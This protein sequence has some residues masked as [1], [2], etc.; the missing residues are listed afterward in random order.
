MV[1][2]KIELMKTPIAWKTIL[3]FVLIAAVFLVLNLT[4]FDKEVKNFFYSLSSPVQK[5]FWQ[6]GDK[7]SDFFAGIF[8]AQDLKK[9][10][11]VLRSQNLGLY[12]QIVSL[13]ELEKENE[14]LRD[15]LNIGLAEEFKLILTQ[16]LSKDI[17]ADSILIN[18]GSKDGILESFPVVTSEKVLL[19][20]IGQVYDNF[21]EVILITNKESSFDAKISEKDIFGVIKGKGRLSADLTL[22]PKD[23]EV[24]IE[25]LVLTTALGGIFPDGV[26][27]GKV[28]EIKRS[29]ID[30]FQTAVIE[31]GFSWTYL[32]DLFIIIEF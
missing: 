12:N 8:L 24:S 9:E 22:L 7:I 31:P 17:S 11:E 28:K 14:T 32:E 4:S 27:V 23:A 6:A 13:K 20:R 18:K 25:D 21:S 19:G 26:L 3:V 15:A 1:C 16:V 5:T 29:D 2:D 30:P 10:T